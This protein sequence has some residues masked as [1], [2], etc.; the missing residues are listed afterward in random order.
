[1]SIEGATFDPPPSMAATDE[2]AQRACFRMADVTVIHSVTTRATG[3]TAMVIGAC[4]VSAW[5]LFNPGCG[6]LVREGPIIGSDVLSV[7]MAR[8]LIRR[9]V[10]QCV[11][12]QGVKS[13]R[14]AWC[15]L[16]H[17]LGKCGD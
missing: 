1:M 5:V 16:L 4:R 17:V 12:K 3:S 7:I 13:L 9:F 10:P 14:S 15:L 11:G 6:V 2:C 8:R